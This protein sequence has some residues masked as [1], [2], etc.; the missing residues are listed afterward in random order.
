MISELDW[1]NAVFNLDDLRISL[2][3][4][5]DAFIGDTKKR[6][7]NKDI[8]V[9]VICRSLPNDDVIVDDRLIDLPG[10]VLL[11]KQVGPEDDSSA[12]M[13]IECDMLWDEISLLWR[14]RVW[15]PVRYW[16]DWEGSV[17]DLSGID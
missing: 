17:H 11:P 3:C 6:R 14:V 16:D 15:E 1:G 2:E 12:D 4:D 7:V 10:V 9:I 5:V 8:C 13:D